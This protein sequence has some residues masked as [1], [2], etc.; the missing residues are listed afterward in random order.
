MVHYYEQAR[1]PTFF[2][3]ECP[4]CDENPKECTEEI[5]RSCPFY[6]IRNPNQEDTC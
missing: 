4:D 5:K 2:I 1:E 6:H 3:H